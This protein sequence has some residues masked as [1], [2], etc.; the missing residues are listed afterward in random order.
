MPLVDNQN[1]EFKT[2]LHEKS[3]IDLTQNF[4]PSNPECQVLESNRECQDSNHG[5]QKVKSSNHACQ[6]V[7]STETKKKT[8]ENE[9]ISEHFIGQPLL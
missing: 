4:Y 7:R 2:R 8:L 1:S 3:V 9:S 6:K 5:L